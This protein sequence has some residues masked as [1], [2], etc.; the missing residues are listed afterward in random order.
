MPLP[1]VSIL[2]ALTLGS[3]RSLSENLKD[4]LNI[5]GTRH[6]VAISGLHIMILSQALMLL[7]IG[8]GL[9]RGQAFYF[10]FTFDKSGK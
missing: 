10:T 2:E 9:W 1:E 8:L 6:I 3:K 7:L 5:T 4:Q